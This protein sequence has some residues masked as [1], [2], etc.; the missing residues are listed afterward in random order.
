MKK[1]FIIG[2]IAAGVVIVL[3]FVNYKWSTVLP[4]GMTLITLPGLSQ[5]Y[6]AG[7]SITNP[8]AS[9]A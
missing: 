5:A 4:S 6:S 1:L 9:A 8:P 7:Y 2:A 3:N